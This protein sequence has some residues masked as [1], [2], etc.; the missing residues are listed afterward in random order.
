[1]AVASQVAAKHIT[2]IHN[3]I[4]TNNVTLLHVSGTVPAHHSKE[5]EK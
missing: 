4:S 2:Y 3:K 5:N 1:M